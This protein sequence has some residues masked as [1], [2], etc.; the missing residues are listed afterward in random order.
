MRKAVRLLCPWDRHVDARSAWPSLNSIGSQTFAFCQ[1]NLISIRHQV[2]TSAV[3]VGLWS[4][5]A[6]THRLRGGLI[7]FRPR[8]GLDACLFDA[9][10]APQAATNS[11]N[12]SLLR[13]DIY[14]FART[15][16]ALAAQRRNLNSPARKCRVGPAYQGVRFSGRHRYTTPRGEHGEP[17]QH[18]YRH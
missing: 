7:M 15:S 2:S 1:R 17:R 5:P 11:T 12:E 18:C 4:A 3:P 14:I 10:F 9:Q 13:S 6:T 8:G 16:D